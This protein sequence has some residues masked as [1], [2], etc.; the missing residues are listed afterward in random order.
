MVC[1]TAIEGEPTVSMTP[2]LRETEPLDP[3]MLTRNVPSGAVPLA[4]KVSV[5]APVPAG[6]AEV[7]NAAVTPAGRPTTARFTPAADVAVTVK[8]AVVF[9][10]SLC[11]PGDM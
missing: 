10:S 1:P 2:V 9:K 11:E 3:I 6:I 4:V 5:A 7:L 8:F